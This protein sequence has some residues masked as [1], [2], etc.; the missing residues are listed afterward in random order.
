MLSLEWAIIFNENITNLG[1]LIGTASVQLFTALIQ[2]F[3]NY[4]T[5][6]QNL[7]NNIV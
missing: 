1:N 7:R 5:L 4:L 6:R 2:S 3:A